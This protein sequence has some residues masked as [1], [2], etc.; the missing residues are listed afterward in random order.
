MG[1]IFWMST[2]TFSSE[3]TSRFIVPALNFLF[4][5]LTPYQLDMIHGLIR[6]TGHVTE[7]FLLGILFFHAFR[8]N[9]SQRWQSKWT[10]YALIGVAFYAV[11]DELHQSFVSSRT[12][13]I[14]DVG[15][16]SAGGILSQIAIIF[17]WKIM[18]R[19]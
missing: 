11:S 17:R 5:G 19:R 1:V 12:A 15:I 8:G 14:V 2:G 9:S 4:P 13:S 16:D 18:S 10:I 6:K 7:Y 3:Q